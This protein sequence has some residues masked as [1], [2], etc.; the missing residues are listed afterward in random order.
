MADEARTTGISGKGV[1]RKSKEKEKYKKDMQK[2]VLLF[3]AKKD[4]FMSDTGLWD[5]K[6]NYAV[7]A[8]PGIKNSIA[9]LAAAGSNCVP[10]QRRSSSCICSTVL[11]V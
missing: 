5:R 10:E 6:K 1:V 9:A 2:A 8:Y 3:G 4:R 7:R 11:G